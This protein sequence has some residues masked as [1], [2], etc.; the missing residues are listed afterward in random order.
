MVIVQNIVFRV[1]I[2]IGLSKVGENS[3]KY[4]KSQRVV[5]AFRKNVAKKHSSSILEKRLERLQR[6][7]V[8]RDINSF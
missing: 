6:T 5:R 8:L 2:L 1:K 3:I 7:N 4:Q